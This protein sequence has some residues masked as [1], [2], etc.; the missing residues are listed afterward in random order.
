MPSRRS[1]YDYYMAS[2]TRNNLKRKGELETVGALLESTK[3]SHMDVDMQERFI[4]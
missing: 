3:E 4:K 2:L 1:I